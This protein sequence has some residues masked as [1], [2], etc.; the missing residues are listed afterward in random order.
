MTPR[1]LHRW[2]S[3]WLGILVLGFLGWAWV[4]SIV[5][6]DRI[7]WMEA[8]STDI[9]AFGSRSGRVYVTSALVKFPPSSERYIRYYSLLAEKP[10]WKSDGLVIKPGI[11]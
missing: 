3:F 2:K 10:G 7:V 11:G 9:F 6:D 1:P 5:Y 8:G 4:R